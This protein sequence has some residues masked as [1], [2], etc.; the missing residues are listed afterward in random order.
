MSE[1]TDRDYLAHIREAVNRTALYTEKM[2]YEGFLGDIKTQD[3]VVRNIEIIGEAVKNLSEELRKV[4]F[5]FS[6][7]NCLKEVFPKELSH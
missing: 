3:A 4:F 7:L 6:L 5:Q 2:T 1:R